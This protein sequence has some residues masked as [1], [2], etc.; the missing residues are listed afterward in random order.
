MRIKVIFFDAIDT[1]FKPYPD[2][3]T[4]YRKKIKEI[5]GM[6]ISETKMK[7]V[8]D[9][10]VMDTEEAAARDLGKNK[11]LAWDRFNQRILLLLE[12]QGDSALAGNQLLFET[13]RN[14]NNFRLFDDVLPTLK[15][16][17]SLGYTISCISNEDKSLYDFFEHFAIKKYFNHI[18]ISDE[19]KIEKP[20]PLIFLKA[21]ELEAI[22]ANQGLHVGDSLKSDYFGALEVGLHAVLLDREEKFQDNGD[23]AKINNLSEIFNFLGE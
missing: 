17:T 15:K 22:R 23:I 12:Y 18:V 11:L 14:P 13:W 7:E 21:I 19:I 6:E 5:T 9:E 16:L 8:W 10:I 1:L 3:M 2:K 4:L 20:N